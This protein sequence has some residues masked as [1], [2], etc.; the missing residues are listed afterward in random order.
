M[1]KKEKVEQG[2][3]RPVYQVRARGAGLS[4]EIRE[5]SLRRGSRGKALKKARTWQ[6]VAVHC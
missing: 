2:M 6:T 3:G 1:E 5:A 4:R